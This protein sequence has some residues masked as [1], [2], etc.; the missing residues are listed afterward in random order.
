MHLALEL[1]QSKQVSADPEAGPRP[2]AHRAAQADRRVRRRPSRWSRRWATTG[3][4]SSWPA[5]TIRPAPRPS[6]SGAPSSSSGSPTRPRRSRR[7]SRPWTGRSG[8]WASRAEGAPAAALRRAAAA[9][10]RHRPRSRHQGQ[11]CARSRL[12]GP[13]TAPRADTA[14]VA[15]AAVLS[16]VSSGLIQWPARAARPGEYMVPETAFPRVDSLLNIPA[17]ARQLPR[18]IVLRWSSALRPASGWSRYRFLYALDDAPHHH[19]QQPGG[20]PGPDRSAHQ[21]S[22]RHLRARSRRR[23]QVR[24]G[25]RHAT[26][27]TTWRSCSTAGC[28]AARR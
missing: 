4:W 7:R 26:S 6:C 12:P 27:A 11:R 16:G 8:A 14:A 15:A 13:R 10:R 2:G 28:R 5:S 1:D 20:R 22:D 19:R 17:V 21:R 18:G 23:P 25:D 9:R 3:S 24:R